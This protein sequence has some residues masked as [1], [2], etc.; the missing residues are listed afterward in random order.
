MNKKIKLTIGG[1]LIALIVVL[2]LSSVTTRN[3]TYYHTPK[4]ILTD[5]LAFESRTIRVMGLVKPGSLTVSSQGMVNH[6]EISETSDEYLSVSYRGALPDMFREGQGVVVEGV[7]DKS[8][9]FTASTL[10]VKHTEE[11]KTQ[12]HD[13]DKKEFYKSL[14]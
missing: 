2:V 3:L 9:S 11:Y 12:D 13:A 1:V 6:F 4:E 8:G 5:P 14:K 7:M 10:L